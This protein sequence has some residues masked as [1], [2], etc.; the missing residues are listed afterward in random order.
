MCRCVLNVVALTLIIIGALNW[1]L[2]GFFQFDLVAW[3]FQGN[4]G[5][6]SRIIY[7]IIGLAGVW[8]LGFFCKCKSLCCCCGKKEN[9]GCGCCK[10]CGKSYDKC[11][12]SGKKDG[13]CHCCG[14][15]NGSCGCTCKKPE[16]KGP[17]SCCKM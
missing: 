7:A 9:G 8:G 17:G 3:L 11:C 4:T 14:K 5:W 16:D 1:G 15:Q 6:V 12:C 10:G 13:S 2:W